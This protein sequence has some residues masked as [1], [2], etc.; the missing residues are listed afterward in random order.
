FSPYGSAF[1]TDAII[2]QR[3]IEIDSGLK[4]VM[5]VVKVRDSAHS[6]E[7]RQFTITEGRIVI[8]EPLQGYDGLLGGRPQHAPDRPFGA[9]RAI[10]VLL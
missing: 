4:R 10:E 9:G 7:I 6:S 8:G 5:A 1:L 3:Y 2:V